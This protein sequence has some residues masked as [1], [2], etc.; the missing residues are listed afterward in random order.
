MM[1]SKLSLRFSGFLVVTGIAFLFFCLWADGHIRAN[2]KG[3]LYNTVSE[4][5]VNDVGL[6]LG[7]SKFIRGEIINPYF[8]KR[9]IAAAELFRAGKIKH[10]IVS[11]DNTS[12]SY[13]EPRDMKSMLMKFGVPEHSITCDYAGLR[14]FDSIFR[15]KGIFGL[16][17]F[18]IISQE[19]HNER[20]LYIAECLGL[21]CIAY[22]ARPVYRGFNSKLREYVA[23]GKAV[24]DLNVLGT[25]PKYLGDPIPIV[26]SQ[27]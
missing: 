25:G 23:R 2:A 1:W 19:F 5:P 10:I 11:G 4:I 16:N 27:R 22:N 15:A 26:I 14:T 12:R 7:T 24:L 20:A 6:V 13:N 17:S 18:T 21:N 9:I 3:K 8:K